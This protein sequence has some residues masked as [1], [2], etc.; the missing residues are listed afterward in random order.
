MF[1]FIRSPGCVPW[2]CFDLLG[3]E[4]PKICQHYVQ[5]PNDVK[6]EFVHESNPETDTVVVSWR[7]SYYGE[8]IHRSPGGDPVVL[9]AL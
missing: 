1:P 8:M 2:P 4:D 9:R 5:A 7:P 6:V 3:K